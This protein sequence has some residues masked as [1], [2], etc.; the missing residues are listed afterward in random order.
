MLENSDP[1][2]PNDREITEILEY[3]G[4]QVFKMRVSQR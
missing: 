4:T 3:I 1:Q 2:N